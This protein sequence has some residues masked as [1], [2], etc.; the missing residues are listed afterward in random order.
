[1]YLGRIMEIAGSHDLTAA[2]RHPYTGALLSAV[3]VPDPRLASRRKRQVLVGDV[4]S[5]TNPP[6]GC[7]FHTRCARA[8]EV[9]RAEG[10]AH[11]DEGDPEV[12]VACSTEIPELDAA[13]DVAHGCACWYPLTEAESTEVG[14]APTAS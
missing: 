10:S 9:A 6:S 12:P 5:P 8:R 1:M 7:R 11:R 13:A 3:P 14:V 4:P 2:P